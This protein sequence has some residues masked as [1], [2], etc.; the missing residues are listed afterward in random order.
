[1]FLLAP[2]NSIDAVKSLFEETATVTLLISDGA[3]AIVDKISKAV[4]L[5]QVTV[6]ELHELLDEEP[7]AVIPFS[8]TFDE[9]RLQPWIILHTSGS[10]GTPKPIVLRHGYSTT[11]DA[12]EPYRSIHTRGL[13]D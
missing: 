1:M 5:P 4:P 9:Y 7:V 2:S 10:T 12:G 13:R 3:P 6:P 11:I 8:K